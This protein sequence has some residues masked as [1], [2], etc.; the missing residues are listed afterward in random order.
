MNEH[1]ETAYEVRE[2][3]TRL[4]SRVDALATKEWVRD[5][6]EPIKNAAVETQHAMTSLSDQF[7][8]LFAGHTELLKERSEREREDHEQKSW[9]YILTKKWAPV[10]GFILTLISLIGAV[11]GF[12]AW[13]IL[14]YVLPHAK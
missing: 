10:A 5:L 14:N 7:K 13:W 11:G 4:E 8:A 1:D 6:V 2:R 3:V 12:L 9:H